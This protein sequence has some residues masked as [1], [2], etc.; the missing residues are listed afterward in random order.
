MLQ[1][2]EHQKNQKAQKQDPFRLF[3]LFRCK[4]IKNQDVAVTRTSEKPE[5]TETRPL[6]IILVIPM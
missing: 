6:P 4:R 1:S 3:W 2:Q 5:S